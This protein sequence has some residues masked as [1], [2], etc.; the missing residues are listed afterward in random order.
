MRFISLELIKAIVYNP[1]ALVE[2]LSESRGTLQKDH[3]CRLTAPLE[4]RYLLKLSD[5][6]K[7]LIKTST[8]TMHQDIKI[9][10]IRMRE[11]PNDDIDMQ[12]MELS[13]TCR[14]S[15]WSQHK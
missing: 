15:Q 10:V 13:Q 7:T 9:A 3:I 11:M 6:S 12:L 2:E 14:G 4:E 8:M 1:K 5:T